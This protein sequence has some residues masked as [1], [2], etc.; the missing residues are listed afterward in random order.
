MRH[1]NRRPLFPIP[2][3]LTSNRTLEAI[4]R[5]AASPNNK[6]LIKEDIYKAKRRVGGVEIQEAREVLNKMYYFKCAYCE[7]IEY[8]PEVEHYRPKKGVT[9][10]NTHHGYY[11][12]CYE[13]TNL[14]PSCHSCNTETG[15]RDQ[16]PIMAT[17]VIGP[18][19][20]P[21]YKLDRSH[22][23]LDQHP[24]LT[25]QPCLLH[26]E[27]DH[28][29]T[30]AYF[31]FFHNGKMEGI[32]QEGR[33]E[34]TIVICDLNRQNLLKLRQRLIIDDLLFVIKAGVSHFLEGQARDENGLKTYLTTVFERLIEKQSPEEPFS[35][36]AIYV[37]EHFDELIVPLMPTPEQGEAISTAF[38]NFKTAHPD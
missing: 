36:M 9:E 4:E 12:L 14:L 16:F 5:I 25:E 7:S 8:K 19:F 24:L 26:P 23:L 32:D 1:N 21:D 13:W 38:A 28:P 18:T 17:R 37:Y 34:R 3:K 20:T 31:K 11:W 35:L 15:K 22:C 33:G 10:D 2:V 27:I 29:D 6:D 30:G